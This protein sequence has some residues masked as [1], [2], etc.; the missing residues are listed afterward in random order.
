[1]NAHQSCNGATGAAHRTHHSNGIY[2]FSF[3]RF[4][5]SRDEHLIIHKSNTTHT[6]T[7][8]VGCP[9]FRF[10][11]IITTRLLQTH[12][13]PLF[14]KL[15]N[16][17]RPALEPKEASTR[18]Q[19]S[20]RIRSVPRGKGFALVSAFRAVVPARKGSVALWARNRPIRV[21]IGGRE[22][23]GRGAGFGEMASGR[24]K[25]CSRRTDA[26]RI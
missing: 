1:L 11:S 4:A 17:Q 25:F 6:H 7:L 20:L 18:K 13:L 23:L 26:L 21:G 16:K 24:R 15:A 8:G 12:L 9:R 14:V 10:R 19:S 2:T 3:R 22:G 5:G